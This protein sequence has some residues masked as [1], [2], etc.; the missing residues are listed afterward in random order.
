MT[1]PRA[2]WEYDLRPKGD[3]QT[4]VYSVWIDGFCQFVWLTVAQKWLQ[5]TASLNDLKDMAIAQVKELKF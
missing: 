5:E 1:P 4:L 2:C 3:M